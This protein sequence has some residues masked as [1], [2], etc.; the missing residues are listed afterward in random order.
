[1]HRVLISDNV[2]PECVKILQEA[3]GIEVDYNTELSPVEF[4]K[5][6]PEYDALI[7]RSATKVSGDAIAA[8]KKLKVI[9]RA[10]TGVD[11]VD[12]VKATDA[13]IVV[14]NTPGGNTVST[15]EHTFSLMMALSRNIPQADRSIKDGRWDR[16]K[17]SGV[18]LR[19]KTLGIIGL[20]NIGQALAKRAN[21]FEMK[22]IGFDPFITKEIAQSFGIELATLDEIWAKSD[23]ITVHTPLND[24]TRH[25]V[26]GDTLAKCRDG[27]RIIN[28][29]RGGIVDEAALLEALESGKVAGAA[30]DVYEHEP[31]N[32]S[33]LVM[34]EN[35]VSTPHLGASTAEAQDIVAVMVAE[36]I[37][38]FLIDGEVKHAVNMPTIS[39]E[40]YKRLEP[41]ITL[42]Y[43]LGAILGQLGEGQF[44]RIGMTYYG[45]VHNYDTWPLTS[46][47]LQGLFTCSYSEEVNLINAISNAE[48]LGIKI[49]EIKSSEIK[50]YK[51]CI[52]VSISSD[53][54]EIAIL[55]TIFGTNNP[56]I[57]NFKG[58]ELDFVPE[59]NLLV[60]GNKDRP[61]IIGEI[62]TVL[63]GK[64]INIAHMTWARKKPGGEAIVVLRT[65]EKL[66]SDTFG[67][68]K[69]ID[70]I[71]WATCVE[72]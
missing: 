57:V 32:Q 8:A 26:N 2:A 39:P 18:E 62:G 23:Y 43:K 10:G 36:Q 38:N 63:G 33:P 66:N 7:V 3:E 22:V 12:V 20:G 69:K 41:F 59:G 64:D 48:K 40:E 25:L 65:D 1:M 28:C 14:M 30:I 16:K 50:D 17:Y 46:S 19:G 45:D 9:G 35:V 44:K 15:A 31:P 29:A 37:R 70:G 11:N 42:G 72:L 24:S 67:D 55:G 21:G 49:D 4:I 13:G 53:S 54:G 5:I 6:I 27:V 60:C 68:V 51:N 61:G 52:E 47:I 71:E 56:R 58:F 34:H